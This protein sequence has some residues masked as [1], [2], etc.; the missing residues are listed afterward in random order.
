MR[1]CH[2][3]ALSRGNSLQRTC[4]KCE[5]RA[6]GIEPLAGGPWQKLIR[7]INSPATVGT[8]VGEFGKDEVWVR[9]VGYPTLAVKTETR[10]GRGT[11]NVG[12]REQRLN[13]FAPG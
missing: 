3:C 13:I 11:R 10:R 12:R 8:P 1:T 7:G 9:D 6:R 4:V 5:R 2:D